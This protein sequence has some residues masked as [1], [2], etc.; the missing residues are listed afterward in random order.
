MDE[1]I[2]SMLLM[3]V[4]FYEEAAARMTATLRAIDRPEYENYSLS[5]RRLRGGEVA[6]WLT[7]T[8]L[9][10]TPDNERPR[11]Q[12]V[13]QLRLPEKL[14]S[15]REKLQLRYYLKKAIPRATQN[16]QLLKNCHRKLLTI[17]SNL[18]E[19][20]KGFPSA[21]ACRE[22]RLLRK[23]SENAEFRFFQKLRTDPDYHPEDRIHSTKRGEKVRSKAECMIADALY[24]RGI[25]YVYEPLLLINGQEFHP[26][27][28][29]F[30]YADGRLYIWEHCGSMDKLSYR[31]DVAWRTTQYFM[32]DYNAGDNLIMTYETAKSPLLSETIEE[33]INH[34]L[35]SWRFKEIL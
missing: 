14:T 12:R 29:I 19:L 4:R 16:A 13:R 28:V 18:I 20:E 17:Q 32:E 24:L 25:D 33:T 9:T 27:F 15:L 30:S 6:Y 5:A 22:E 11:R 7:E 21:Y 3:A 34:Y 8:A 1:F 31:N 2:L 35:Y 23:F 10:H 26:D